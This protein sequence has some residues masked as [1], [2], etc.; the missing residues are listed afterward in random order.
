MDSSAASLPAWQRASMGR[1]KA[2][3]RL[4]NRSKIEDNCERTDIMFAKTKNQI[5]RTMFSR[6]AVCGFALCAISAYS[7]AVSAQQAVGSP[8]SIYSQSAAISLEDLE[9]AFWICDYAATVHG[10]DAT[11]VEICI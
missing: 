1:I 7:G 3:S 2:A 5:G 6:L 8:Q 9:S 10:V 11:P 4:T